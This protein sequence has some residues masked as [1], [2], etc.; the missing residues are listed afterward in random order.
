[1]NELIRRAAW[2]ALAGILAFALGLAPLS[3]Q[4]TT[5][6]KDRLEALVGRMRTTTREYYDKNWKDDLTEEQQQ[7]VM[8]KRPGLEFIPEFEAL[9]SDA[10]GTDVAASAR[11]EVLSIQCDFQKKED[12]AKTLER[13][14]AESIGSKALKDLPMTLMYS[15]RHIGGKEH[16]IVTL[17]KLLEKSP[18][19]EVKASSLFTLGQVYCGEKSSDVQKAKGRKCF[20]RLIGEFGAIKSYRSTYKEAAESFLFEL[21]HLQIGMQAPDFETIDENGTKFKLSDYR[22]KVLV[23]DF[24]GNW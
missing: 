4:E 12:A 13:L 14:L 6:P 2:L 24:W 17:E 23:I 11:M 15:Y 22:G 7:A 16:S 20:E 18:H 9:A 10:K 8:A 5:T 3:A 21:D 19:P 1:M